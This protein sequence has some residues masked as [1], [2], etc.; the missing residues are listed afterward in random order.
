MSDEP[1]VGYWRAGH[2]GHLTVAEN[3]E[4][5]AACDGRG[6]CTWRRSSEEPHH[7]AAR[8][9]TDAERAALADLRRTLLADMRTKAETARVRAATE[10]PRAGSRSRAR[11]DREGFRAQNHITLSRRLE[12][13]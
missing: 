9:P 6:P 7:Q 5:D 12:T 8:Q 11:A 4:H 13:P 3:R 10:M 2:G 1:Q